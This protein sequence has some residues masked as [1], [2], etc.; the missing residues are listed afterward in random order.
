MG[1]G[2]S[3]KTASNDEDEFI[4][5]VMTYHFDRLI[6]THVFPLTTLRTIDGEEG[7]IQLFIENAKFCIPVCGKWIYF[8]FPASPNVNTLRLLTLSSDHN[9][10]NYLF[11][12]VGRV[13][14]IDGSRAFTGGDDV[15]K[16]VAEHLHAHPEKFNLDP[17]FVSK[18]EQ[19]V[20]STSPGNST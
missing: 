18:L 8:N 13:V 3:F 6:G 1:Y 2:V 20:S 16:K 10:Q 5:E 12:Y 15:V 4:R 7:S 14:A 9:L 17:T 19:L 11:P